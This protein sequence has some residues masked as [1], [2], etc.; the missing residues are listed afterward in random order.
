MGNKRLQDVQYEQPYSMSQAHCG[1]GGR[2]R[3]SQERQ[4]IRRTESAG[5][6]GAATHS[7]P[8]VK[9]SYTKPVRA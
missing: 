6:S 4:T 2:E 1:R 3:Q 7:V 8:M 9:A 5:H